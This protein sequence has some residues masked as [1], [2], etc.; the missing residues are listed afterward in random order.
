MQ[1]ESAIDVIF[2]I[3]ELV[4]KQSE[5]I[6]MLEKTVAVLNNKANGAVLQEAAKV[7]SQVKPVVAEPVSAVPSPTKPEE[8][9]PD[10]EAVHS[11]AKNIRVW[12][13][14]Q[15]EEG[16]NIHGVEVKIKDDKDRLIKTTKSNRAG[17]WLAFLPPGQYT[18]EFSMPGV[19]SEFRLFKLTPG[20]KEV[21]VT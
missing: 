2:E 17:I 10:V 11:Q 3:R 14:L 13:T 18:A 6:A 7:F 5:R 16:K 9:K 19:E 21:E 12:G 15:D 4:K 8:A 1:E 20:Q